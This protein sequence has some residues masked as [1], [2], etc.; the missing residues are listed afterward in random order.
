MLKKKSPAF[1]FKALVFLLQSDDVMR[2]TWPAFE[3]FEKF[4][5]IIDNS[6]NQGHGR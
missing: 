4:C 5:K 6:M 2:K 1:F 3:T